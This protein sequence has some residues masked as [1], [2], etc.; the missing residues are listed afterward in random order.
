MACSRVE[1]FEDDAK[2]AVRDTAFSDRVQVHAFTDA[3]EERKDDPWSRPAR[4][5]VES[6]SNEEQDS[7]TALPGFGFE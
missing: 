2:I 5:V 1:T 3:H 6:L 4:K 7:V